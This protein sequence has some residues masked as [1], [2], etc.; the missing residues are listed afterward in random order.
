MDNTFCSKCGSLIFPN[1]KKCG[2]CGQN[3]SRPAENGL[4]LF[5]DAETIQKKVIDKENP[6]APYLPYEPREMQLDIIADIRKAIDDGRHIV[7]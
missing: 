6:L 4:E 7:V 1:Q 5:A 2:V 3:A